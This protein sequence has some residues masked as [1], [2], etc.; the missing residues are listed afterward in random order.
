MNTLTIEINISN[1]IDVRLVKLQL[2][3][4]LI[5]CENYNSLFI[6]HFVF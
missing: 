6:S 3:G 1:F 4:F 2:W 5:E